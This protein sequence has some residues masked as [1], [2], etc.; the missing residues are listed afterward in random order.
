MTEEKRKASSET[1]LLIDLKTSSK[2]IDELWSSSE[3]LLKVSTS[4]GKELKAV[5]CCSKEV[6]LSTYVE[7]IPVLRRNSIDGNKLVGSMVRERTLVAYKASVTKFDEELSGEDG[8]SVCCID[9][10]RG[11]GRRRNSRRHKFWH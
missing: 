3:E 4:V 7:G 8:T 10:I 11:W 9:T 5:P 1:G 6:W 2:V